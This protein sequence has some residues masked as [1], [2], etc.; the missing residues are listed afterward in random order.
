MEWVL[1]HEKDNSD[2]D[3]DDDDEDEDED[4]D[5]DDDDDDDHD[6][7][8]MMHDAWCMMHEQLYL[9]KLQFLYLI[10]FV[11]TFVSSV[12]SFFPVKVLLCYFAAVYSGF[13]ILGSIRKKRYKKSRDPRK[14]QKQKVICT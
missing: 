6:A 10:S 14:R 8:S 11:H 12:P 9:Q 2:D 1:R 13:E 4:E 7:W 5:E 3:D